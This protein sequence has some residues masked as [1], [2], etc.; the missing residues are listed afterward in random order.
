[1]V[2]CSIIVSLSRLSWY[3][4]SCS[5]SLFGAMRVSRHVEG[6]IENVTVVIGTNREEQR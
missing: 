5:V 2:L 3:D 6:E 1:M 4:Y